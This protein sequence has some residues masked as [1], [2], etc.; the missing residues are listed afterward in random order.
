MAG[1][2]A[3]AG[4][5]LVVGRLLIR[6]GKVDSHRRTMIGAF[7]LSSLFLFLY[8]AYKASRGFEN[9]T[10]NAVGA[11]KTAYLV[12]LF[13]HLGMAITV[14]VLAILLLRWAGRPRHAKLARVAWPIWMYVSVTGV[15]IYVLLHHL[16]PS[17]A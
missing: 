12:L 17:P 13:T 2:N 6:R 14:P 1:L 10:Y 8:V 3:L 7:G 11:A 15:I 4:I 16:N 5:L 9:T